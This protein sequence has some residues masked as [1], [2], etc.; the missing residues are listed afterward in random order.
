VLSNSLSFLKIPYQPYNI[1]LTMSKYLEC[2]NLELPVFSKKDSIEWNVRIN[3]FGIS[4]PVRGQRGKDYSGEFS[5]LSY[6][7]L[8][9]SVAFG[10]NK[11]WAIAIGVQYMSAS[12]T[13]NF[14][15]VSPKT[16]S[17]YYSLVNYTWDG[18]E[19]PLSVFFNLRLNGIN[20]Y[21]GLTSSMILT[22]K[23][24]VS[25]FYFSPELPDGDVVAAALNTN[26]HLAF[27]TIIGLEKSIS[28][29]FSAGFE[30]RLTIRELGFNF[31][32]SDRSAESLPPLLATYNSKR[33][34]EIRS[35]TDMTKLNFILSEVSFR[36]SYRLFS[37]YISF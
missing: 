8:G 29:R 13:N 9:A 30:Y 14:A 18:L 16:D 24:V 11:P 31:V 12:T 2:K 36:L 5:N 7:G 25:E 33:T 26:H 20:P 17:R 34:S 27:G 32:R 15:N 3:R 37:R 35:A 28:K 10:V 6:S 22:N 1:A 4:G 19:I 21:F 23:L